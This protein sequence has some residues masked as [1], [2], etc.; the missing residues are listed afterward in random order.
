MNHFTRFP[1]HLDYAFI[2]DA[3]KRDALRIVRM[4]APDGK[5]I[6]T[7]YVAIN[8]RRN[9]KS[10]GSFKVNLASGRWADFAVGEGGGDMISLVEYL[11]DFSS[12]YSAAKWLAEYL[13]LDPVS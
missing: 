6:G 7:E 11:C 4:L 12:Y 10:L 2:K 3:A 5:V 9:D 1:R 13:D 8:P